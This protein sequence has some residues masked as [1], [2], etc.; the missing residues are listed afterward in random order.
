M[1]RIAARTGAPAPLS[2][3]LYDLPR[4]LQELAYAPRELQD[5]HV[6]VDGTGVV[7]FDP[8]DPDD[9]RPLRYRTQLPPW[10]DQTLVELA[11]RLRS[12]IVLG[13][14]R[15][16]TPGLPQGQAFVHPFTADGLA[17][18]HNGWISDFRGRVARP[19]VAEV[20][21]DAVGLLDAVSDSAVLFLLALDAHRAGAGLLDAAVR[22][23]EIAAVVTA[24]AGCTATLTLVLA[25]RT[26]VAAVNA[27]VGRP[28]NSLYAHAGPTGFLLG[29]EPLDPALDWAPVPAGATA[30]LTPTALELSS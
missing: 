8:D 5:G 6:N 17:G 13:A 10:G 11:P 7:W 15:S 12:H 29:S 23:T 25:D 16:T 20:S 28:A 4:S 21:D 3:L 14:V 30:L 9:P 27:A 22:A 24:S 19:L 2:H 18:T 26:G 1:C